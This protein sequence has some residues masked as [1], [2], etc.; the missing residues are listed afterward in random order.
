MQSPKGSG[1]LTGTDGAYVLA[2]VDGLVGYCESVEDPGTPGMPV[3]QLFA[4]C[5]A[6]HDIACILSPLNSA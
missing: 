2:L 6:C 3:T 1:E 5:G 4:C